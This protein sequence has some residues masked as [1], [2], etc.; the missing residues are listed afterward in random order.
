[1]SH[2]VRHELRTSDDR[3]V[4]LAV[5]RDD[6]TADRWAQALNAAGVDS[7]VRIGD[8]VEL[9]GRPSA[10]SGAAAGPDFLFAFPLYVPA[11]QRDAAARALID[12]GWDGRHGSRGGAL[13][14]SLVIRGALGALAAAA[15]VALLLLARG[16]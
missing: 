10:L 9:L 3:W 11:E 16:A 6:T 7:E 13:A 4:L 12:A 14:P 8:A 5:A 2:D 15:V 1:M